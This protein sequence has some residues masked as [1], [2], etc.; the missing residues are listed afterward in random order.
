MAVGWGGS[1]SEGDDAVRGVDAVGGV[2]V[3]PDA[4]G[5][6]V[7]EAVFAGRQVDRDGTGAVAAADE[8]VGT[9]GPV[10]ERAD[11]ADVAVR[12]VG[13]QAEGDAGLGAE[14]PGAL[15]HMYLLGV[16]PGCPDAA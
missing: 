10:V 11:D 8:A 1:G 13:R 7:A 3:E 9:G 4:A 5:G 2:V 15:D 16:S 12:L 6:E 14:K